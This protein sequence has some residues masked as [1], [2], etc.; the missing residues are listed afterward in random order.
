V[1][2]G[3]PAVMR[4]RIAAAAVSPV[5][6]GSAGSCSRARIWAFCAVSICLSRVVSAAAWGVAVRGGGVDGGA[7]QSGPDVPYA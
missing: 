1:Q 2:L 6:P 4:A 7:G 3:E 5:S